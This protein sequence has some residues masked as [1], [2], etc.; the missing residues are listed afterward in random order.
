MIA[1]RIQVAL[2]TA[3]LA[4][5][6]WLLVT[7]VPAAHLWLA[8]T[9]PGTCLFAYWAGRSKALREVFGNLEAPVYAAVAFLAVALPVGIPQPSPSRVPGFICAG[10]SLL[11]AHSLWALGRWPGGVRDTYPVPIASS[12]GEALRVSVP[13]AIGLGVLVTVLQLLRRLSG[14]EDRAVQLS[15]IPAIAASYIAAALLGGGVVGLLRTLTRWP[16]GLMLLGMVGAFLVY[17]VFG[18]VLAAV[19]SI[20][21]SIESAAFM[22]FG[23]AVIIGPACAYA[24]VEL[25]SD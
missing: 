19:G 9:G 11:T 24:W 23:M 2:V 10:V 4:L 18:L 3:L 1:Y 12:V 17:G 25:G 5:F 7:T 21:G 22:G 20:E 15:E 14:Y 6:L 13:F 16:L 8:V